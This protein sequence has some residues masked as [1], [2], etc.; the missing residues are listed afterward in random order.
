MCKFFAGGDE[1]MEVAEKLG[2]TPKEIR[3]LDKRTLNPC[4]A[5]LAFIAQRCHIS[6]GDLYDVLNECG[7]PVVADFL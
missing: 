2:L 5:V 7:L 6:V 4:E 1:W 3:Y